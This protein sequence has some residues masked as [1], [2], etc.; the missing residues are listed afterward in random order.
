MH[1]KD[2]QATGTFDAANE[3]WALA[4]VNEAP[5]AMSKGWPSN[6]RLKR[7]GRQDKATQVNHGS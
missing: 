5:W 4:S 7:T 6:S 1:A 3:A 2:A